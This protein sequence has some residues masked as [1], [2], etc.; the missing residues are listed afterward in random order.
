MQQRFLLITPG[1]SGS[2][3]LRATLNSIEGLL[4]K[5][6]VFNRSHHDEES[7]NR[8]LNKKWHRK[9]LGSVSNRES[10]STSPL[11]F[12]LSGLVNGFINDLI[13]TN[14][15]EEYLG[16]TVSLDQ[17]YAY[18]QIHAHI[19]DWK[20]IYLTRK[21]LLRLTLS[22]MKAR[23]SGNYEM[24]DDRVVELDPQLVEDH[25]ALYEEW[26]SGFLEGV[27]PDLILH[28]EDL[29][30]NYSNSVKSIVQL[31]EMKA[32]EYTISGLEKVN[33]SES[34]RWV[35]NLEEIKDYLSKSSKIG[36]EIKD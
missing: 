16:F 26:E 15:K 11:N 25:I 28:Y 13:N 2:T 29:F 23:T 14:S 35:A 24:P 21:D 30:E 12:T 34:G 36:F 19:A 1:R 7:F 32:A 5:D 10:L 18:P 4:L 33:H 17:W 20:L 27:K 3:H 31:L 22:L 9:L 8:Y 6:E